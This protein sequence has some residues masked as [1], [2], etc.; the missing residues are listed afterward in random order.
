MSAPP[1]SAAAATETLF[2]V[3]VDRDLEHEAGSEPIEHAGKPDGAFAAC[4]AQASSGRIV[5]EK[6]PTVSAPAASPPAPLRNDR[7]PM[8]LAGRF[9]RSRRSQLLPSRH[10]RPQSASPTQRAAHK[11]H[12]LASSFHRPT[13]AVTLAIAMARPANIPRRGRH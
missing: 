6:A 1:A 5:S 12:G 7:R 13:N 8:W 9:L 3:P 2:Q 10:A 11:L 4:R